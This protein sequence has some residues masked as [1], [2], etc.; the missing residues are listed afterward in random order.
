MV[1][2][3]ELYNFLFFLDFF[4]RQQA[5]LEDFLSRFNSK[6]IPFRIGKSTKLRKP[7]IFCK[8]FIKSIRNYIFLKRSYSKLF[9]KFSYNNILN[10]GL[11]PECSKSSVNV[12]FWMRVCNDLL[13]DNI[14]SII[15][16]LLSYQHTKMQCKNFLRSTLYKLENH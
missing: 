12:T 3:Y 13:K 14:F 16:W 1:K 9:K 6:V 4:L 8:M 7:S 15:C 10:P 2:W 5:D 11:A